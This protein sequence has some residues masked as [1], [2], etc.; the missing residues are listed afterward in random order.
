MS[1]LVRCKMWRAGTRPATEGSRAVIRSTVAAVVLLVS[2]LGVVP[3]ALAANPTSL[4]VSQSAAFAA[5]GHSC[6]GIQE[7]AFATGFDAVSGDPVG[8]VYLQTRCGGSGRGGG[9][10]TTTYSAWLAVQW[11]FAG[12]LVTSSRLTGAPGVDPAFSATDAYGDTVYN[13]NSQAYLNVPLPDAPANVTVT[14]SPSG[15]QVSWAPQASPAITSSTVTATAE[16][17]P[18]VTATVAGTASAA[19][20]G[21]LQPLTTYEITVVSTDGAG[22]SAPSE[23]VILTTPAGSIVPSAPT[24]V[25]ARWAGNNLLSASWRTPAPGDSPIDQYE[26]TISGSDGGGTVTQRS[27]GRL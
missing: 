21:P 24:G 23:P 4:L 6:G 22:S 25:S 8:H 1:R 2:G 13:G 17:A 12:G 11:D 5:L 14:P 26:I 9:Y 19:V 18:T 15:Y 27:R 10:K 3:A 7:Q 16:G 20:V